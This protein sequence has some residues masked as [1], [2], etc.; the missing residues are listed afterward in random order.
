MDDNPEL[1]V[2]EQSCELG[3]DMS[4]PNL[5]DQ[6]N[7]TSKYWPSNNV[8]QDY[9][10][11]DA[12]KPISAFPIL[13]RVCFDLPMNQSSCTLNMTF[14]P[15]S[16]VKRKEPHSPIEDE[17]FLG[18]LS[19]MP[20]VDPKTGEARDQTLIWQ[21]KKAGRIPRLTA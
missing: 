11:T 17:E 13:D 5:Y 12:N 18:Y 7:S 20:G 6:F 8:S 16:E 4:F 2:G 21:L 15:I 14:Y 3:C 9:W 1:F 10:V 19:L